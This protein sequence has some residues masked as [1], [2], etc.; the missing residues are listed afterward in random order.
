MNTVFISYRRETTA[1]EARALFNELLGKLGKNSVFMDVD[2]IALGRDF[3][4]ALQKT[5]EPCD[6]MLV[7]IGRDWADVKDEEG[8][9]AYTIPV[10]RPPGDRSGAQARHRRHADPGAGGAYARPRA[11]TRRY[12]GPG[13][14]QWI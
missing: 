14:S 3:R 9:H 7:L 8:D 6:L 12:Q 11:I 1:G 5:L 2:S 13:L 4:G 10:I